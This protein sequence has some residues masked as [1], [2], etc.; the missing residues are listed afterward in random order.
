MTKSNDSIGAAASTS[1]A[2]SDVKRKR[3]RPFIAS[4]T[5]GFDA[6]VDITLEMLQNVEPSDITRASLARRANVAPALIRY[7]FNNRDSLLRTALQTLNER[8][9]LSA[10]ENPAT[11]PTERIVARVKALLGFKSANRF[12]HRLMI[13]EMAQSTDEASRSAFHDIATASIKRYGSYIE[14]GVADGS[15]RNVDPA[16]LYMAI[17]GMCDF[18]VHASPLLSTELADRPPATLQEEYGAFMCDLLLNGLR[19]R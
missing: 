15:L 18:F 16:F 11:S 7:Y 13:D 3:G 10:P 2:V 1:P 17:V 4:G 12:Y 5:V 14:A 19:P 6:L 8:R 9:A